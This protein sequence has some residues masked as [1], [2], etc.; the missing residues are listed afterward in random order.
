MRLIGHLENELRARTFGNYL[1]V[2]GIDNHLEF[3]KDE[4]WAIW[5]NEEDKLDQAAKLLATFR[6]NPRD[7]RYQNEAK[8]A[9]QMRTQQEKEDSAHRKK[10]RTRGQLFR[11]MASYGFGPLTFL[12]I[13]ASVAVFILSR[14]G[15]DVEPVRGLFISEQLGGNRNFSM[16]LPEVRH[17]E[18]WRLFTP[19]LIHSTWLHIFFNMLCL[20]DLGSM[21]ESRQ[22]MGH[23]ALLVLVFA[24]ASDFG[25]YYVS[26]PGFGGMSGVIYGLLGYAWIRGKF[27][28]A[29]GLSLHPSTVNILLIWL[30]LCYTSLL[31]LRAANT[32]HAVGLGMGVVWGYL[33]SL[34][35]H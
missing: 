9:A 26:G 21:I 29:S 18:F 16:M 19:I 30:V 1:F 34:G 7:P 13:V 5:V 17:G 4:G 10:V 32:A 27:D 8:S 33:S 22:S 15:N 14:F 24:A 12:V 2:Q 3:Q 25:Q 20:R 35:H 23:L 6:E 28:P 11:S 31:G